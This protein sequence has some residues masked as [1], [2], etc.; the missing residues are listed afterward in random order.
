MVSGGRDEGQERRGFRT[1]IPADRPVVRTPF[2]HEP[3][4]AEGM[5]H[6]A[7]M[8]EFMDHDVFHRFGRQKQ[9]L[10]VQRDVFSGRTAAPASFLIADREVFIRNSAFF[11]ERPEHGRKPFLRLADQVEAQSLLH[12]FRT[13]DRAGNE[14][15]GPDLSCADPA[16]VSPFV[17]DR[18]MLGSQ[19]EVE[20]RG[21]HC[22]R[23]LRGGKG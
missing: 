9:H 11:R 14:N 8:A 10:G 15:M 13:Q 22:R 17:A 18:K 3:P 6:L 1:D 16:D 21:I 12:P 7:D 20:I 4:E 5:I 23:G 2:F 19:L